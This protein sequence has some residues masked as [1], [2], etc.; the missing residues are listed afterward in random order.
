MH[1]YVR[2]QEERRTKRRTVS[3]ALDVVRQVLGSEAPPPGRLRVG[4]LRLPSGDCTALVD[5]VFPDLEC[6]VSLPTSARFQARSGGASQPSIFEISQLERAQVFSDGTV[7]LADGSQLRAVEVLPTYLPYEP[8]ILDERILWMIPASA[9]AARAS[10]GDLARY[11]LR[12][13]LLGRKID[14][15]PVE[16]TLGQ[17]HKAA[18]LNLCVP[19]TPSVL[20]T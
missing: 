16:L 12:D 6:I 1:N 17:S 19:R 18:G 5:L 20:S 3:D 13:R 10:S 11:R 7:L 2:L 8:S 4:P 14:I 9:S 15:L